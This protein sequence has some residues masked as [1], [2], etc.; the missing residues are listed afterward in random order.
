MDT[1]IDFRQVVHALSDTL[2]LVGVDEIQ[3]GKRVAFM[4]RECGRAMGLAEPDLDRL[5]HAALLHDCGVSSTAVH[6][7]LV[8]EMDWEGADEHCQ[9]GAALLA[10]HELFA[11]LAPLVRYHHTHWE[12]LAGVAVPAEVALAS[13]C[14]YLTDRVDALTANRDRSELLL[15]RDDIR[16]TI[17]RHRDSFFAPQLVDIFLRVSTSEFFWLTLEP[18]HLDLYLAEMTQTARPHRLTHDS[19]LRMARIFATIVDAKSPFTVEHSLG[20]ARLAKRLGRLLGLN[21]G[22]CQKLEVAGLLHDLGK[23]RVPDEILEKPAPLDRRERAVMMHH[24]FESYQILRRI[25]GFAGIAEMAAFHHETLAGDGYP[26]HLTGPRLSLEARI[27]AVADIFQALAQ[28]RPYR[29]ALAPTEIMAILHGLADTNHL[30]NRVVD[31]VADNLATCYGEAA[32]SLCE[33]CGRAASPAELDNR[34]G[35]GVLCPECRSEA[36]SCGCAD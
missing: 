2:D 3:H 7:R 4:A 1:D 12:D 24:S 26:F 14:I 21:A 25:K 17:S 34:G 29:P 20:V 35:H 15:A 30:D 33:G 23:L 16:N 19:F 27:I 22:V 32:A 28:N 31:V 10:G 8:N 11:D 6:R 13:N 36:T 5:Y 9:L 18:R